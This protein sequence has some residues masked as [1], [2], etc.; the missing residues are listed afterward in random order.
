MCYGWLNELRNLIKYSAIIAHKLKKCKY[1]TMINVMSIKK[2][3]IK[4]LNYK[5]IGE[6]ELEKKTN[7][8]R[9]QWVNIKRE[10]TRVNENHIDAIS[11]LF[12]EYNYWLI[13][14]KTIPE[15]GQISPEKQEENNE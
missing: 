1:C 3:I 9:M 14:G 7:I 15:A 5:Q 10:R 11:K 6:T 13:S 12:P 8:P 4:L 2:R